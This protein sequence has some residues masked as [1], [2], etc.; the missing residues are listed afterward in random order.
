MVISAYKTSSAKKGLKK[1]SIK[2]KPATRMAQV[3]GYL[4]ADMLK[5]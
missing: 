5:Y 1:G 2:N 3:A 4:I